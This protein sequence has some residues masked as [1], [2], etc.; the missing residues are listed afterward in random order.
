MAT[1]STATKSTATKAKAAT[2]SQKDAT[3]KST[4]Q[5]A[6]STLTKDQA[7]AEVD[8]LSALLA[9]ETDPKAKSTIRRQRRT[10][11]KAHGLFVPVSERKA[12]KQKATVEKAATK[13]TAKA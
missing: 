12:A 9:K 4:R 13:K 10:I 1:K 2:K 6:A 11:Q 7:I 8:R 5:P 3:E